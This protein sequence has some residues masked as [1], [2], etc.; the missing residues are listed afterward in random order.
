MVTV[1]V[2]GEDAAVGLG[3]GGQRLRWRTDNGHRLA[4]ADPKVNA[5]TTASQPKTTR[6]MAPAMRPSGNARFC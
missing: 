5:T 6:A 2:R 4:G 1:V 3:D